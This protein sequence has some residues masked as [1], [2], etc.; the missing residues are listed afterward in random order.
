MRDKG[1]ETIQWWKLE[2]NEEISIKGVERMF[3][4]NVPPW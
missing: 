1:G 2:R 3:V 4:N